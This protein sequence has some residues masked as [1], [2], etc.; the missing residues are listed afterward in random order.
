MVTPGLELP[1]PLRPDPSWCALVESLTLRPL[2]TAFGV[3]PDHS[4]LAGRGGERPEVGIMTAPGRRYRR[5]AQLDS[6]AHQIVAA[7]GGRWWLRGWPARL[8]ERAVA[9]ALGR[10]L[11]VLAPHGAVRQRLT[12][13]RGLAQL[14]PAGPLM[15]AV[16]GGSLLAFDAD[17]RLRWRRALPGWSPSVERRVWSD[18]EGTRIWVADSG[19]ISELDGA[20][21][22]RWRAE[23]PAPPPP[24][25]VSG[26]DRRQAAE[27]LGVAPDAPARQLRRAFH[28]GA[29]ATHPDRHPDDPRAAERFRAVAKAYRLLREGSPQGRLPG[30]AAMVQVSDLAA[31]GPDGVWVGTGS[32]SWHRLD[33][34][35]REVEHGRRRGGGPARL[36]VDEKGQLAAVGGDGALE[37]ADGTRVPLPPGWDYRLHTSVAGVVAQGRDRLLLI[38][39]EARVQASRILRPVRA[40]WVGAD[41]YLFSADGDFRRLR[42]SSPAPPADPP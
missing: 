11:L 33:A 29:K 19:G 22:R 28:R 17:G 38:G 8:R 18:P 41:L 6:P 32:G 14:L 3:A 34:G 39:P 37:L 2:V 25:P 31:A 12:L 7:A 10:E 40:E 36:A 16:A 23:L 42:P 13:D 27:L 26:A 20:G 4:V 21:A 35:G 15:L 1:S 24:G 30:A 5:L 9:P